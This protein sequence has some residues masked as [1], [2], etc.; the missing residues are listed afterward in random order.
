MRPAARSA[1]GPAAVRLVILRAGLAVGLLCAPGAALA[2]DSP[3]GSLT[4]NVGLFS[5]YVFRGISQTGGDL[6]LQGGADYAHPSGFYLG[7]WGSNVGWIEDFQGYD[8]GNLE[9][10]VYAGFRGRFGD[11]G[12]TYD[13]GAIQFLYPGDRPG[14]VTEADT[15]EA[16]AGL[17]WKW[18]TL[19]YSYDFSS[20]AFGFADARGS[21]YLEVGATI[22]F[23]ATGLSGLAHWGAYRFENN[24]VLDYDDW[25][26][27]ITYDLGKAGALATGVTLGVTYSDTDAD[28][29]V[30]TDANGVDLGG[31]A[32]TV[33]IS[34]AF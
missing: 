2:A 26:L 14:G 4:A 12:F 23:G 28:P 20:S 1:R 13:L 7:V 9:L 19:K 34:R 11:S 29:N 21:D 25:R 22:P 24:Q 30:W 15:S 3:A 5:D 31:S 33:W 8:S 16:Y 27:G 17:G 10:D 18:I 32:T 6:A